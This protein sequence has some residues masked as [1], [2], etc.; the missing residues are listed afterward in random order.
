MYLSV[1]SLAHR[2]LA[3]CMRD[4]WQS[5]SSRLGFSTN[6]PFC[7]SFFSKP[8]PSNWQLQ[9]SQQSAPREA[10]GYL[11]DY[12]RVRASGIQ[13]K[14]Y[15]RVPWMS[16][17]VFLCPFL[18]IFHTSEINPVQNSLY[19]GNDGLGV[20]EALLVISLPFFACYCLHPLLSLSETFTDK[21][22]TFSSHLCIT[23]I[24]IE[25]TPL[26]FLWP[27]CTVLIQ[28]WRVSSSHRTTI[29]W[30]GAKQ[31]VLSRLAIHVHSTTQA[32]L[33]VLFLPTPATYASHPSCLERVQLR[34]LS[35]CGSCTSVL[36]FAPT[37]ATI[38][39]TTT[40]LLY[41]AN[42]MLTGLF[43]L[44][45]NDTLSGHWVFGVGPLGVLLPLCFCPSF[46]PQQAVVL[47]FF[48]LW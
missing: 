18:L 22:S 17:L 12:R 7:C 13:R 5:S 46:L 43:F 24:I 20:P 11:W 40:L 29:H 30:V 15:V 36:P 10:V 19:V 42:L 6:S 39:Q 35:S 38:K 21:K 14:G 32:V 2:A 37:S 25:W 45:G 33:G 23:S 8:Q 41:G 3:S 26:H 28:C 9:Q 48:I 27:P 31:L 34:A 16:Y 44:S 47:R 1:N 4:R